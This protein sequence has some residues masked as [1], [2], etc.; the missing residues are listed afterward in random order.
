EGAMT[1]AGTFP[2]NAT[3]QLVQAN[4]VAAK[5]DAPR[6]SLAPASATATPPGLLTFAPASSQDVSLT[7]TNTTGAPATGVKL[8]ISTPRQW[9]SVVA[10]GANTS[11]TISAPV[12][13]GA[14]VS[15]TFKVTSGTAAF[16]GDLV[17]NVSWTT[18]NGRTQSETTMEKVRNVSPVKINE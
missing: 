13:P 16:N 9:T 5:Y 15:A 4:V 8:N 10:G 1:A 12:A 17:G 3:D 11:V 7:F 18:P 2:T 6:L 14:G